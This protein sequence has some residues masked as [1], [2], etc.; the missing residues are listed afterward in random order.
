MVVADILML[1][2]Y[3]WRV[4]SDLGHGGLQL[5]LI[6][7]RY[8][9]VL[10]Y[11]SLYTG[12]I[13]M[14]L[15]SLE[16]FFKI[17]RSLSVVSTLL[18]RVHVAKTLALLSWA[19]M[20]FFSLPN[21]I[22]TNQPMTKNFSCMALKSKLG[23]HWHEVSAHFNVGI[24]WL[25]FLLMVFCYTSIACQVYRS[26]KRVQQ[27][28]SKAGRRSNQ[29][30]F[31]LLAV[32]IICF[33]PYH[34]CR[35][36]YTVSQRTVGGFGGNNKFILFQMEL[37]D[38]VMT[39]EALTNITNDLDEIYSM[40]N[41]TQ[42]AAPCE[43]SKIPVHPVFIFAYSVVFFISLA[44][45]C[46]TMKVFFCSKHKVFSSITIYMKNLAAADFF[47]CLCLP[48]R[49]AN[50]ASSSEITGN[51]YC[52]FGATAFYINM[53]ASILFMDFIAANRY[54]KIVRPLETHAL[55]M[56]HTAR[57]ISVATW[58]LLVATSSIYLI[59]F[60]LTSWGTNRKPGRIGCDAFHSDQLRVVYK[61]TH[62]VSMVLFS[63]VLFSLI[64]LYWRTLQKI[65][66]V[67]LSTL[68]TSSKQTFR[69]S[70]R[71]MLVL[72]VV[73]CV[74]FVPYHMNFRAQVSLRK[75]KDLQ[76][77]DRSQQ[78]QTNFSMILSIGNWFVKVFLHSKLENT[79]KR[80]FTTSSYSRS[81]F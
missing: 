36:P 73:F 21:A 16:R 6:V 51:I 68:S 4:A 3:P 67:Q 47:L 15:I 37:S 31:I 55:Q 27:D 49:I 77:N 32:F 14:S 13:F 39:A 45:N 10:F 53:Y 5:K 29:S 81:I 57:Y 34:V 25:A 1:F 78:R 33:V 12:I 35:V 54:L 22:L 24:F 7:C 60:L 59:I 74:C 71:N 76:G 50:Y 43:Q 23:Q 17:V 48:L 30:I 44:L 80:G 64:V 26:Y 65:R 19:I 72:V 52:S 40:S 66:K 11:L 9:A 28:K 8:T 2:T 79:L 62:S 58:L 63:S 69:R 42:T 38:V 41:V 56:V 75:K 46:I 20:V 61:I 18:Q 70:K